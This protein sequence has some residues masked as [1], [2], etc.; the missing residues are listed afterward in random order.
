MSRIKFD[1]ACDVDKAKFLTVI[2]TELVNTMIGLDSFW[3]NIPEDKQFTYTDLKTPQLINEVR[4][5]LD[6]SEIKI[7]FYKSSWFFRNVVAHVKNKQ[8]NTVYLNTRNPNFYQLKGE[9]LEDDIRDKINTVMHEL[10][11]IADNR[12]GYSFGHGDNSPQKKQNSFPYWMGVYASKFFK[13]DEFF[14]KLNVL[15]GSYTFEFG[16]VT[17]SNIR[18]IKD[19]RS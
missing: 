3:N 12:S 9:S 18:M 13:N 7:G 8:P 1:F 4:F 5:Q 17:F 10:I 19:F 14:T 16:G 6:K 2:A 15:R 11:H